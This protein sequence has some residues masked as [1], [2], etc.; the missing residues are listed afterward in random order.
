MHIHS[1]GIGRSEDCLGA[2]DFLGRAVRH[3]QKVVGFDGG[4]L[5][6]HAVFRHAYAVERCTQGTQP[7]YYDSVLDAGDR[8][9]GQI[10]QYSNRPNGGNEN[11]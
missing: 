6:D 4:F 11:K 9:R 5:F 1:R 10:P 2:D 3:Y 8:Y 7:A